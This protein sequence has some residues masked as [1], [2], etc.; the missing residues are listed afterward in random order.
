MPVTYSDSPAYEYQQFGKG[1]VRRRA[2]SSDEWEACDPPAQ[3]KAAIAEQ[4][5]RKRAV[6]SRTMFSGGAAA[7]KV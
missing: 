2:D 6:K 1:F 3:V 7:K 4:T 5:A